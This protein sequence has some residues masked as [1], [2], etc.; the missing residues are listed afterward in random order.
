V[1]DL[2]SVPR[3][4]RGFVQRR[5]KSSYTYPIMLDWE[6]KIATRYK[7]KE[8]AANVYLL[9]ADGKPLKHA[10]GKVDAAAVAAIAELALA[11]K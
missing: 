5:F 1:A 10:A 2:S 3:P 6:G 11:K 9:G 8:G 4:L 7:A